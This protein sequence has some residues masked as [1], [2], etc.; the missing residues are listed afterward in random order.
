MNP[1]DV[2]QPATGVPP[3]D[4]T[5]Q[6]VARVFRGFRFDITAP[7]GDPHWIQISTISQPALLARCVERLTDRYDG[8]RDVAAAFVAMRL[9]SVVSGPL[10]GAYLLE[11]RVP[12]LDPATASVRTDNALEFSR[13]ALGTTRFAGLLYDPAADHPDHSP[14]QPGVLADTLTEILERLVRPVLDHLRELAPFGRRG[15]WGLTADSIGGCALAAA[16][17]THLDHLPAWTMAND[18]LDRLQARGN[19]V[20]NRPRPLVVTCQ[21]QEFPFNIRGTCCLRFKADEHGE[22]HDPIFGAYCHSCP[23]VDDV[24]LHRHYLDNALERLSDSPG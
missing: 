3:L 19:P 18:I 20:N 1:N 23:L 4:A 9:A 11:H 12:L 21:G 6:C 7:I 2:V 10:I 15:L 5:R 16:R 22:H 8:H 24:T 17:E 14:V 13:L